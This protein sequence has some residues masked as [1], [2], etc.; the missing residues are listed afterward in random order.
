PINKPKKPI[1]K[2]WWMILIYVFVGFVIVGSVVGGE[3]DDATAENEV[4][5]EPS[6]TEDETKKDE[7]SEPT[8][9]PT[10]EDIPRE[11][12]SALSSAEH[13][14]EMINI[15]NP[16]IDPQLPSAYCNQFTAA[17]AQHAVDII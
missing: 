16:R 10:E 5:Q 15:A 1:W 7:S 11:Y 9:E 2:R 14:S 12:E 4:T 13:Y 3:E 6:T 17:A 8:E